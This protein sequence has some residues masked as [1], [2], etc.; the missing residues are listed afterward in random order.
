MA[1]DVAVFSAN[2]SMTIKG[3]NNVGG[4]IGALTGNR[5]SSVIYGIKKK[6]FL[7]MVVSVTNTLIVLFM[8]EWL[9]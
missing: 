9:L 8:G 2:D 1:T 7:P 4:I 5:N 3:T 6:D